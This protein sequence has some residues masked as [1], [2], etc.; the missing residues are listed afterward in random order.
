M[1]PRRPQRDGHAGD[2]DVAV[3]GRSR[4]EARPAAA[5]TLK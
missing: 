1:D 5:Q 2:A 3:P 4:P